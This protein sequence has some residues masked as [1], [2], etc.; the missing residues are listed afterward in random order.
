MGEVIRCV[1]V[2]RG[3]RNGTL[4]RHKP[5]LDRFNDKL[6]RINFSII[7]IC[8]PCESASYEDISNNEVFANS[9]VISLK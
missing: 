5:Q 2:I 7:A 9:V 6:G 4:F 8:V 1:K 3:S